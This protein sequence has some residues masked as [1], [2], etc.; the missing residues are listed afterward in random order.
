MTRTPLPARVRIAS[1]PPA[2]RSPQQ[3]DD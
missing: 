2:D 1:V 3:L